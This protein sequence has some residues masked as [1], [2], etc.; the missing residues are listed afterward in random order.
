M[1][2]YSIKK[3]TWKF[4]QKSNAFVTGFHKKKR[5]CHRKPKTKLTVDNDNNKKLNWI[6]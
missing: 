3:N 4:K 2:D 1:C 6:E 5:S